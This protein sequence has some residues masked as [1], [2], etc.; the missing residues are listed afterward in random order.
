MA[1]KDNEG[2]YIVSALVRERLKAANK[3]FHA[4]DNISEFISEVEK[5]DLVNELTFKLS[6]IHISEP[7]RQVR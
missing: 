2:V 4:S 1:K 5:D 3:R 7:T 6:L